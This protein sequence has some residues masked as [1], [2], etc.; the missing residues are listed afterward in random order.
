MKSKLK[1]KPIILE[2]RPYKFKLQEQKVKPCSVNEGNRYESIVYAELATALNVNEVEEFFENYVNDDDSYISILSF[3]LMNYQ[4]YNLI[5]A[6]TSKCL[7][8]S[9]RFMMKA[10]VDQPCMNYSTM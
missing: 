5:Y 6:I 1:H 3:Q 8:S 2:S 9:S 10:G 4:G 7:L